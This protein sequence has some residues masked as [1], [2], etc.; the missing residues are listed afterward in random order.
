M[1]STNQ[2]PE[3]FAAEKKYLSAASVN[4]RIFWL[5]EM[6]RYFKKHKGS[7]KMLAELKKRLIKFREKAEKGKKV[8][9][10]K[11]GIRKEGFQV[12]LIGLTNSGKSSLLKRLTNAETIVSDIMYATHEPVIGTMNYEGVKCQV[13]DFPAIEGKDI[14]FGVVNTAD[15]LLIVV[16]R[17]D[18]I[19]EIEKYLGRASGDRLVILNKVDLLGENEKRKLRD[20]T[21]SRR[22]DGILISCVSGE[23][24]DLVKKK[25]FELMRVIRVYTKDPKK[26]KSREPVVLPIGSS[27]ENVA[28]SIYKGFSKKIKEVRLTGPSGKFANQRVGLRH[29]LK[30]LDVVEF[31][32]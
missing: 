14:D 9:K 30:D 15:L 20:R 8:G 27:I 31:R 2:G 26:E 13:I 7:E 12:A 32:D 23:G 21:K 3:Y 5:G 4:E 19:A 10:G 29:K 16:S 22:I 6:I 28:E 1:A 24:I 17:L 25:I 11:K 18:D